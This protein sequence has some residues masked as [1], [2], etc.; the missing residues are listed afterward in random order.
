M[1]IAELVLFVLKDKLIAHGFEGEL[2]ILGFG[3]RE[4]SP[5][6]YRRTHWVPTLDD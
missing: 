6:S 1:T 5:I 4:I 2:E 3:A